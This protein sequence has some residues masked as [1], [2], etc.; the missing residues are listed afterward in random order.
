MQALFAITTKVPKEAL[1][2]TQL[3]GAM[4]CTCLFAKCRNKGKKLH[5]NPNSWGYAF[6]VELAECHRI[7][8]SVFSLTFEGAT[9]GGEPSLVGEGYLKRPSLVGGGG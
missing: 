1:L 8:S 4:Y 7:G 6:G 2:Q 5:L 3:D 9:V